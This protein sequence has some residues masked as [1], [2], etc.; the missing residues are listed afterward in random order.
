MLSQSKQGDM[1]C[2]SCVLR[3]VGY[4]NVVEI[5]LS[6]RHILVISTHV[7]GNLVNMSP[8]FL[9]A[10]ATRGPPAYTPMIKALEVTKGC[11][12]K[13]RRRKVE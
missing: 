9:S 12:V 4:G 3:F 1:R 10:T 2:L 8:K 5:M 13:D 6:S 11:I 7:P